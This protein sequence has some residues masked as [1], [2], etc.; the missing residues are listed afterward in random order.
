M[1]I[2]VCAEDGAGDV[3]ALALSAGELAAHFAEDRVVAVGFFHD[4]VMGEARLAAAS[5]SARLAVGDAV[6]DVLRDRAGE[7]HRFLGD[8]ADLLSQGFRG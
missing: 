5:I 7:D 2:G 6:G 4:E 8:D 1:R 3:D